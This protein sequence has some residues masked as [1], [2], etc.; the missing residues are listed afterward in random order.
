MIDEHV[1]NNPEQLAAF[2]RIVT[3]LLADVQERLVYRAHIYVQSDILGY[4]P[5]AGDLA[6]PEKLEMMESIAESLQQQTTGT[7]V[8]SDSVTSASSQD[9]VRS[10]TGNSPADLHGMWYPPLRRALL[11]LSKLYRS[12]D[13]S[14]FQ[15]LSQEVL[16]AACSALAS[17]AAQIMSNKTPLDAH[18]FHIKHLLILREQIAPFQV[19][20][21]VKEMS[22]D[23]STVR[24]AAI[25]LFQ[26]RNRLFSLSANNALLEFLLEG[27][28]QVRE[29]LKDSRRLAD[30]QLKTTCEAFIDYCGDF[31]IGPVRVYLAKVETFTKANGN[32]SAALKLQPFA[33][34]EAASNFTSESQKNLRSRL[35]VVQRS[36]QLY[37]ANR[38]TE[39]ILFRPVKNLIVNNFSQLQQILTTHYT[40]E[41][42]ALIAAPTP[43]QI[44]VMLTAM[45]LRRP[46]SSSSP[47]AK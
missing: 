9:T 43:E 46:D 32:D 38:E 40:P 15:G 45:L 30:R 14:T 18:L 44:S 27:A 4:K 5:A 34:P 47:D 3:Q 12:V 33:Q 28:P 22:L 2:H 25:G 23:F 29:H 37:L 39:F 31:L 10:H 17:A 21:A 20:F 16:A 11:C 42:Q 36:L 35:P 7:L 24:N 13:R 6:Y 8:R 41:E 19:D 26:K 1:T